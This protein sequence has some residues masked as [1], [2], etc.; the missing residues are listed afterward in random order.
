MAQESMLRLRAAA[1]K[2]A[3]AQDIDAR[4]G[5]D[6][7]DWLQEAAKR[8]WV[9]GPA[10]INPGVLTEARPKAAPEPGPRRLIQKGWDLV[11]LAALTIAYLQYYYLDVNVQIASLPQ[12]IVFVPLTAV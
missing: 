6:L 12:V 10:S 3:A 11:A 9:S 7:A 4:P 2:S 1:R 5:D 8:P